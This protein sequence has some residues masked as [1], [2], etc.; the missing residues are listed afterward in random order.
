[1]RLTNTLKQW[2]AE[3]E[4]DE[5]PEIDEEK[6][7]STTISGITIGDFKL[8]LFFEVMEK[9]EVFKIY[10]YFLDA[11]VPEK[12]LDEVQK[13]ITAISHKMVVGALH[14]LRDERMIRYYGAIDVENA[15]F[16]P[17]HISNL[18]TAGLRTMEH[19]L[20]RY[21]AICFGGKTAEE[22]FEM[23]D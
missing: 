5:E 1:M 9:G 13:L 4:W 22:A 3:K 2:L 23:E 21:M 10:A 17:A 15:A 6:Q 12:K 7:T 16:E 11:K 20:P 8:K 14:L 18:L 19:N